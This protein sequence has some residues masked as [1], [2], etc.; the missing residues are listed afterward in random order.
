MKNKL[1]IN[2]LLYIQFEDKNFNIQTRLQQM[3]PYYI[4]KSGSKDWIPNMKLVRMKSDKELFIDNWI[5]IEKT[6]EDMDFRN[7]I[8]VVDNMYTST[9]K[10]IEEN[11][12][13]KK[14]LSF[15][16]QL[17]EKRNITLL[18][19]CH[20][21]KGTEG[22][23][24]LISDQ[25]QGGKTLSNVVTNIL[26]IHSSTMSPNLRVAKIVKGGRTGKN[27]LYKVPFKLRWI[28][29]TSTFKKEEVIM[30]M[31]AHF[32]TPNKKWQY[33]ILWYVYDNTEMQESSTFTRE[34]FLEYMPDD[35]RDRYDHTI[36]DELK[37]QT[38]KNNLTN[39]L[40]IMKDWGFLGYKGRDKWYF[41][42]SAMRELEHMKVTSE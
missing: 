14:L 33:R 9:N 24:D 1:D 26:M 23:K 8:L 3:L 16:S 2:N 32:T 27:N 15:I 13:L 12:E 19:G 22:V 11:N 35:E 4:D 25:L 21:K 39:L 29:E 28:D 37:A 20:C 10:N 30:N 31:E 6:I 36:E 41:I 17:C 34:K 40:G 5:K 18:L 38:K 42:H 7:G